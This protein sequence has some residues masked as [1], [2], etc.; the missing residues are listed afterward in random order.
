MKDLREQKRHGRPDFPF[1]IYR[2]NLPEYI[3]GYPLHWHE[4]MEVI[5]VVSGTGCITVQAERFAV[6]AGD[7]VLI[8]PQRVHS[9]EQ[10]E[11]EPMEYFNILF[12]LS[13]LDPEH[14]QPI[15]QYG[16]YYLPL[17]DPRNEAITGPVLSLIENRKQTDPAYP[18]LIRSNL[19][20]IAY[21]ILRQLPG[22]LEPDMRRQRNYDRLKVILEYLRENYGRQISV[23]DAAAMCGFSDSHFM[24]LFRELTG[25]SFAQYVKQMRL[26]AA[27]RL[28][29]ESGKRV[30]EIA[31]ETGFRNLS[32]F[33]RSFEA[34]FRMSPSAYRLKR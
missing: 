27:A 5:Y 20:Q 31:E 2:G 3:A 33:T 15:H 30:G 7:V 26:E 25:I 9:I 1:V 23:S 6:R 24:K 11:N 12:R 14:T 8:P 19:Y 17:R 34:Q 10:L 28:L 29:K 16:L 32:Y 4:E 18:L 21:Q 22:D 13:L